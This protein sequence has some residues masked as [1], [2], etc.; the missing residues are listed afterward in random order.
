MD[1]TTLI[2]LSYRIS[3]ASCVGLD[4]I[5]WEVSSRSVYS[6]S[7]YETFSELESKLDHGGVSTVPV[8]VGITVETW[9]CGLVLPGDYGE[10]QNFKG[11][12]QRPSC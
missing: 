8:M 1:K 12:N 3:R 4:V 2:Q 9:L 7:K 6:S 11:I 5:T 10:E